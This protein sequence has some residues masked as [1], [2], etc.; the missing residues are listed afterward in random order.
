MKRRE[1]GILGERL[2]RNFLEEQGYRITET[3]YRCAEGELDIIAQHGGDTVFVEVRAKSQHD[4]GLPEESIT[5]AKMRKLRMVAAH[6]LQNNGLEY[7]SWRIDV[8]ALELK[9]GKIDRI[10]LIQNAVTDEEAG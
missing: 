9:G 1:T 5:A 2:A 10:E 8:V 6:Y 4:F 7:S 3:N